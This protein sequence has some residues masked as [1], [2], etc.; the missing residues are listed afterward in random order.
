M[1]LQKAERHQ[2]KLRIGLSGPSGTT[3]KIKPLQQC[4]GFF[5]FKS[6]SN[7]SNIHNIYFIYWQ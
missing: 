6:T 5:V 7:T 2:V 3:F 1:K 4:R